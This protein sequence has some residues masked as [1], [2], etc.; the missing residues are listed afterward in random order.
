MRPRKNLASSGRQTVKRREENNGE[1]EGL[2]VRQMSHADGMAL[3]LE[4]F[5][6]RANV[7]SRE[8]S[9]AWRRCSRKKRKH[10]E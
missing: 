7:E 6:Q 10:K 1:A 3:T 4:G 5:L 8:W 9:W 2:Q